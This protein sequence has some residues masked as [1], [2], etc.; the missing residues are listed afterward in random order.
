[1]LNFTF[2]KISTFTCSVNRVVPLSY[3]TPTSVNLLYLASTIFCRL[4]IFSFLAK[5]L[6]GV[7]FKPTYLYVY[8]CTV[9]DELDF[10]EGGQL[11]GRDV[12]HYKPSHYM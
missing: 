9:N 7:E 8:K 5:I 3:F 10:A 2:A 1:M 12:K 4:L 6:F 11:L